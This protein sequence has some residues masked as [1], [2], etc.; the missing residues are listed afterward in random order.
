M[1]SLFNYKIVSHN[2]YRESDALEKFVDRIEEELQNI[3]DFYLLLS[4]QNIS[5]KDYEHAQMV[6]QIFEIKNFGKYHN[7]YLETDILLLVNV[8][9]YYT[10]MCLKDDDKDNYLIV[11]D[12]I[13]G[14]MTMACHR[15]AKANNLQYKVSPE[16]V[17][18]IQSIVPDT[19][20]GYTLEVDLEV[21]DKIKGIPIGEM[22][23]LKPKMYIVLPAGHNSKTSDDPD[24]ED[25]KKK[26]GTQKAKG[27]KK[28]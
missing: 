19:E 18:D 15:Y 25:S 4:Q 27:V 1:D 5:K 6:W 22:V 8:F 20:I 10:I 21:P 12:V 13:C 9:M 26:H 3:Q 16:K 23:C 7:F 28:M 14:G 17:P 11:E 2:L 24:S